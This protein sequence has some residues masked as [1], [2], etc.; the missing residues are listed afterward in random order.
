MK[1]VLII[2]VFIALVLSG[3]L[4]EPD[5]GKYTNEVAKAIIEGSIYIGGALIVSAIIRG[6][7]ND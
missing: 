2:S 1:I 3:C 4:S 5:S 7:M 6:F